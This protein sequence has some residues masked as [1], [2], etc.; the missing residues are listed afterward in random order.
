MSTQ[1][2]EFEQGDQVVLVE[3]DTKRIVFICGV[4]IESNEF[5]GSKFVVSHVLGNDLYR[6]ILLHDGYMQCTDYQIHGHLL[7]LHKKKRDL[8]IERLQS[9]LDGFA[10][11]EKHFFV[12]LNS[13]QEFLSS[14]SSVESMKEMP[15]DVC[16]RW[17]NESA[18]FYSAL[19]NVRNVKNSQMG[20]EFCKSKIN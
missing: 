7:Q 16:A 15:E 4:P 9:L 3:F 17:R 11:V 12:S 14:I 10:E 20:I 2:E 13:L 1:T 8:N 18:A 6:C 5:L 19:R